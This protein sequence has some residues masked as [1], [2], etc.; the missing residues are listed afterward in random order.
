VEKMKIAWIFGAGLLARGFV[1]PLL[2]GQY[3]MYFFDTSIQRRMALNERWFPV[4]WKHEIQRISPV[5]APHPSQTGDCK[6]PDLIITCVGPKGFPILVDDLAKLKLN[7]PILTLE[8]DPKAAN[9]LKE[10]GLDAYSGIASVSVPDPGNWIYQ[11]HRGAVLG[12]HYGQLFIPKELL[13]RCRL[14]ANDYVPIRSYSDHKQIWDQKTLLHLAPHALCAYIGIHRGY[15]FIHE[16]MNE[17]GREIN[18][19]VIPIIEYLTDLYGARKYW[20]SVWEKETLRFSDAHLADS[21][22]RVGRNPKL[23]VS[24]G[25]RLMLGLHIAGG[26]LWEEAAATAL[27]LGYE[28]KAKKAL[29]V[30]PLENEIKKRIKKIKTD[31]GIPAEFSGYFQE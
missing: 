19:A 26:P 27:Y 18:S 25:E 17:M 10:R 4:I 5:V 16:I 7:A 23:K 20:E 12:D 30:L 31:V 11:F 24:A 9:K 15:G 13:D 21:V 22:Y 29:A 14:T 28:K 1:A 3:L 6:K 2:Q 8:N